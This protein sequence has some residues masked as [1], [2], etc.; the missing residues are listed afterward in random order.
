MCHLPAFAEGQQDSQETSYE[1]IA[2]DIEKFQ[3]SGIPAATLLNAAWCLALHFYTG[4]DHISFGSADE[5]GRTVIKTYTL[6][7][8]DT[9][10]DI[11]TQSA[12]SSTCGTE[13]G[14]DVTET[15]ETDQVSSFFNTV[16][17]LTSALDGSPKRNGVKALGATLSNGIQLAVEG[18]IDGT[19]ISECLLLFRSSFMSQAEAQ[20]LAATL[21]HLLHELSYSNDKPI[22]D[23]QLSKRDRDQ[24][25]QWNSVQTFQSECLLHEAITQMARERPDAGAIDAWDGRLNYKGLEITSNLLGKH[26]IRQGVAPGSFVL[27]NFEKSLWAVVSWL[28]VLKAGAACVFLDRRQ[29]INRV[30]QIIGTT[31]ATHALTDSSA[32]T[33]LLKLGM[34]VVQVPSQVPLLNGLH[35]DGGQTWPRPHPEDAAFIIFTSGSTGTPKGVILTHSGIYTTAQDM[36]QSL[37]VRRDSRILQFCSYTFDMSVAD[38]VTSLLAGACICIPSESDR[39]DHLQK[40]LQ[41]VH[42][43]WAILTPTVARLLNPNMTPDMKTLILGGELVRESDIRP[44]V[45]AGVHVYNGYGPA[46][47]TFLA[48]ITPGPIIGRASSIGRGLNMR[49]WIV[50]PVRNQLAPIGAVGELVVEGPVLAVGYLN[51]PTKTAKS[52]IS[53]PRWAQLDIHDMTTRR[54]FYKTGDLARYLSDGSLE[55]IG[56]ADTQIK[57]GGQRIELSD[58]EHHIRTIT[59]V[60]DSAVVYLKHGPL[61]GRLTAVV[62][63]SHTSAVT[64]E[65]G[66]SFHPCDD[67]FVS[68][69]KSQL[70]QAVARYMVPSVWFRVTSLPFSPTGKLD[71]PAL[72]R[73]LETFVQ[74]SPVD[75]PFQDANLKTT[76][77]N[78]TEVMLWRVCSNVL[79][80]PLNRVNLDRSFFALG[81]DSITT[82]QVVSTLR[83]AGKSLRVKDL[84]SSS[85]LRE[86]ASKIGE[87][88]TRQ[89]LP[90]IRAG[91]RFPT[92]PIQQMFFKLSMSRNTR[93]HFNQSVSVRLRERRD[94]NLI[95]KAIAG[96]VARHSM[97][98]ARFEQATSGRWMQYITEDI[99]ESYQFEYHPSTTSDLRARLMLES[100]SS[101]SAEEG[102]LIRV[103]MFEGSGVQYLFLVIHHLVV[104]LVSWRIILEELE[105]SLT[106]DKPTFGNSFPFLDWVKQQREFARTVSIDRVLPQPVPASNFTFWGIEQT[107][108]TYADVREKRFSI[109]QDVTKDILF[110]SH[111]ALQTEPIDILIAALLRSFGKTFP[112]RQ[113]PAIFTE[114]HGREPWNDQIDISRTVGWFTTVYPIYVG[115]FQDILDLVRKVK[116]ARKRTPNNGFDYFSASF[117]ES[118]P[119]NA[120]EDHFP[121]EIIFNY[122]G[123]YQLLEKK[124]SLLRQESWSA[125]EA[126]DDMSPELQRFSL[127]EIAASV[128]DDRLQFTFAWNFNLRHQSKIELWSASIPQAINQITAVLSSSSRQLTLSDLGQF[129]ITYPELDALVS[130]IRQIPAISSLEDVEDVYPCSPMQ[131]SLALSQSRVDNVYEVDILWEVTSVD[132]A[133]IDPNR[134]ETAWRSVVSRHAALRTV[135]I[136]T[137]ATVGMLDQVVLREHNPQCMHLQ[138]GNSDEAL[139]KLAHYPDKQKGLGRPEPPHRLLICSTGDGRAFLRF[140]VNHIVFD[141]MSLN[142]MLRDLSLAYVGRLVT[143]WDSPYASFIRY[144]R[145]PKLREESIS[146]WKQYLA[147]AE[148]CIFPSL[149][150]VTSGESGQKSAPVLLG[151]THKELKDKLAELEV[152]LPVVIQLVW[153]LV[154]RL[155]TNDSQTVTGYLTS[156]RDAPIAGIE[157]AIGPFISM[158]LCYVDFTQPRSLLDLLKK[159]HEDSVNSAAHQASSLAEIQKAIGIS[160]GILF[161]AGISFMPLLDERAQQGAGLLFEEKSIKDPTEFELALIVET[162]E[163][164]T[165]ISIHYRTSYISDGHATNIAATVNHIL[166]ETLRDPSQTPDEIPAISSHDLQQLWEWNKSCIEPVEECVHHFVERTMHDHPSK[167]A[168]FSWDGSLSYRELDDLSRNLAHQLKNFGLGP[169][170]IVPLC[171]EKSK[172][173][174]VSMLAVL[175][176]GACFVM[177]DP[178]HPNAR[179]IA[180]AEEVE[181]EVLLC[182]PLTQPKFEAIRER[183][184]VVESDSAKVLPPTDPT[185]PVC[186]TVT[187]DN[188]MY[189]VFTSGTTGAPKGSITSHRAYCTGFREHAWAIEVGPESRTLQFSAYSFDASVGDILTTLL[190]GGCICIPSEEDRTAEISNFI[191]QSRA[192]WAGWT[193]SF[194]SL[195]DPDTVPTLTVLLMA[196]EPLPASQVDAWVDR[197]KLLNIYGPSECSVACVVNK[198]V[199]RETNASN[200]GRGYR[201]VTWVVDE[202]DHERLRP[203]GSVGELL[204]EGPILA[205]GYL[206]MPEKTAEVFIDA[207][208]W[209]KNGSHPRTNRLYKTGDLVRYNSD[210]TINFIGRKDTQLKINGQRVEI[211][212]IEQSLRSSIPSAAGPVVVDL[213]K[214]SG[215]HDL[216]AAFINVGTEHTSPKDPDDIIAADPTALEKFQGLVKQIFDTAS[217]LPRYMSPQVFIPLKALPIT[218]AGK[219]DRRALQRVTSRLSRD[220]LVSFT[221]GAKD[222]G[223]TPEERL[224]ADLWRKVL[225]VSSV[226]IHDKFF[227]LGGDSMAAMSLRSEARH[228]GWAISVSDIFSN[229]VLADMAKLMDNAIAPDTA[230]TVEPFSLLEQ[231]ESVPSLVA[232]V[233]QECDVSSDAIEDILPCVP[234]Q[235]GLMAL[236]AR[237]PLA[238]TY[239]LHAPYRLPADIDEIRFRSA[240]EKTTEAH[241]VLRSRI[242]LKPQGALLV[243]MKDT[244][245]VST[246]IC[247]LDEYMDQQRH[248]AF[249]YGTPLLRLGLVREGNDRYFVFNAHH[250]IYDGWSSRLIWDT[251]LQLYRGEQT[252]SAP[253]FQTLVQKLQAT[254][255]GPSEDYW[256]QKMIHRQGESF[257]LVP[258]L[259]KPVARSVTSF[260]FPLPAASV[261]DRNVTSATLIN[262]VWAIINA[263]YSADSTATYGCTLSGRDF[264]LSGIEKL[265]GPTIVTVP[266]Q[267]VVRGDQS[268]TD[269]LNYVQKVSIESI[270]H[271]HLGLYEIQT[272]NSAARQAYDFASLM[273]VHPDAALRLPF[274]DINI[275][276]VPFEMTESY[277]Y[278]LVVEFLPEDEHLLVDVKFDPD[279]MDLELVNLVMHHFNH[280]L[281]GV[282]N[283]GAAAVL[284]DVMNISSEDL[285]RIE[286]WNSGRF[287]STE[288]CVHHLIEKKVREQ[289]D[290][291]AVVS[292]DASLSYAEMDLWAN[293]LSNQ[294]IATNLVDTG[295]F[296]GLCLD[297]SARAVPAMVAILKAGGAFLPLDPDHPPARL[298]ALLEEA[299]VKLVLV[300]PDRLASLSDCMSIRVMPVGD[301]QP[302]Q[303]VTAPLDIAVTPAHAAYLLFTS[304]STGKPKGVVMEHRAWSSA[305]AAQSTYFGFGPH[306]RM[307]QFSSYT[308]DA[309]IFEIFITLTS[310]GCVCAP[311]ESERM[312]N[313]SGY[314]TREKVNA[315][316]STPSVTRLLVPANVPTLKLVMVGG[317]PLA[318]SDIEGWLGQPGVS[319]VN[320][321][322]PTEA[323]VMATGRKVTL[324]DSSSN[325]GVPIGTATWVVSPSTRA[326]APIG[327]VGELCIEGPTLARGYLGDPER[328][329]I[330][331]ERNPPYLPKGKNR[332]I[333][334]TGDLVRYNSDGTLTFVGRSDGQIKL[335]GQRIEIGEIEENIRKAMS[336]NAAFKHVGVELYDSPDSNH[337]PFLAAFLVMNIPYEARVS[338]IGCASMMDPSK[339]SLFQI[340]THLQQ[341][342]RNT[343]PGYMVPSAYVSVE[344]LPTTTSSKRDRVFVKAILSQLS[345][346]GLLFP[347]TSGKGDQGELFGREKLLQGWWAK[348]LKREPESIGAGDHFFALG[349]NSIT[350]I[351]LAGMVR[352]SQYRLTY[353]DIFSFPLLS[354]MASR[355]ATSSSLERPMPKPFELMSAAELDSVVDHVLPLYGI[356][357]EEVEDIYPCTPLQEGLMAVTA[358]NFGAYISSDAMEI[359]EIELPLMREAWKAA[360]KRFELLRTRIILSHEYG[361]FQ[362]V[363]QQEPIW[364][365]AT[366]AQSFLRLVQ[367]LHGYGKPMVHHA[368]VP[369]PKAGVVQVIFSSHHSVYDGWSLGLLRQFVE[370]HLTGG[371]AESDALQTVPFKLFISHLVDQDLTEARSYWREK[372]IGLEALPFPRPPHDPKHQPLATAVLEQAVSLPKPQTHG[373]SATIATIVRAACSLTI[374]HYTASSDTIFGAI[375]TGRENTDI[376]GIE[377]IAGPTIATVPTRTNIDYDSAV[378]DFLAGVQRNSVVESRF[379]QL[380]L[381]GIARISPEC[382]QSCDFGSILVVQPPLNSGSGMII[383]QLRQGPVASPKFFPQAM[384]LD[385]QPSDNSDNMSVTLSYDPEMVG[386]AHAACVL[387]TF[388]TLLVSLI[389]ASPST[390]L[391][392]LAGLSGEHISKINRITRKKEPVLVDVC[393]H[394]LIR[395]QVKVHPNKIAIDSWDGSMTYTELDAASS[396]LAQ[397]L[398]QIG[399]G[400]QKAAPFMFEKSKWAIVSMLAIWKAGGFFV[401][402]DPKSPNRRL[403]HI[404]QATGA[405]IIL[406]STQYSDRCQELECTPVS[407]NEDT[408]PALSEVAAAIQSTVKTHD[409]A[410]VLFTSGTTGVPKGVM[411][412]HKSLSSSLTA[413]GKYM[414]LNTETRFLQS[415]AFTFDVMLLDTFAALINGGCVC[416]PSEYQKM[417]DLTGFIED[418]QINTTWFTTSLSRIIDPDS[419]PSLKTVVMGGEAVLQSDVDRWASKV[420]LIAGYGPTE[421]CIVTLVGELTPS[422]PPNTIGWPVI[423][424]A[425]VVNP[426][427]SSELAPIGGVG[428]LCIEGP[429]VARGYLGNDE[430][431]K[432][433][434]IDTP[435]WLPETFPN[436]R[437]YRT[438]DFV[439]Y[440]TDGTLSFFSRKDSQV[441]I[442]GQRVELSEIEEAIRHHVPSWLDVAVDVFNPEGRDQQILAAVF[443]AGERF[444]QASSGANASMELVGFMKKLSK[445][446]KD[447]LSETLPGH[448]IPDAYIPLPRL[449]VQTSGKLDRRALQV[450]VNSMSLKSIAAYANEESHVQKPQTE[451][452]CVLARLWYTTLKISAETSLSTSDNFFSLGGDSILAMRLVAL[453]RAEGYSLAVAQIFSCPTLSGMASKMQ[454]AETNGQPAV[455]RPSNTSISRA[456]SVLRIEIANNHNFELHRV[457]DVYPCTYMQESFVEDSIQVPGAHVVQFIFTLDEKIDLSR[458]HMAIDRCFASFPIL[459]TR[460]VR[461]ST[462]LCQVVL[463]DQISWQEFSNASLDSVLRNDKLIPTSL[464]DALT[465]VSVVYKSENLDTCLIWTLHH[466]LYDAWSLRLLLDAVDEAYR[467]DALQIDSQLPFKQLT[468]KIASRDAAVDRSF[469]ASY[470]AGAGNSP[471]FG[472]LFVRNPVK[473]MRAEYQLPLPRKVEGTTLTATI[474]SAWIRLV[475]A[476][477]RSQDVTIGYLVTGRAASIP[478][479]E[480]CMGPAISKIPLRVRFESGDSTADV[481]EKVH[482][483]LTRL[484]PYELSGLKTVK[485]ASQDAFDACRFPLDLTVHPHGTLSFAGE[486]IGMRFKGGEVAAAPPGSFAVEC[487]IKDDGI[488]ISTQWDKRAAQKEEMDDLLEKFEAVLLG[489]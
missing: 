110:N 45:D 451:S 79:N 320:A 215:E 146:Y 206:K 283:A 438:G 42:A 464:G 457:E 41:D 440:N 124:D 462:Q 46:E 425:W 350:A 232:E 355:V 415:C 154:L 445:T 302:S 274:E 298:Q 398:Q 6:D 167:E 7:R 408:V 351:R 83:L 333:Y 254:P 161:N 463:S 225:H 16:V 205:R 67:D 235:E 179:V 422:T 375:V 487:T 233:S 117:I 212:E 473:D 304:G 209:L 479:I 131:E 234:M 358:R 256:R 454:K 291:P 53:T 223:R 295:D 121:A 267:F 376:A 84:L 427:K 43:T 21:S 325:I 364:H 228:R 145:D 436:T 316:I 208:T 402:L 252:G 360:F 286:T 384:V 447:R 12:F 156:G 395:R 58:I 202:N 310:G 284:A 192:T 24:I 137:S 313:L 262:A 35:D 434:F 485:S 461:H 15:A 73:E 477:T 147:G 138:A 109:S 237:Q 379:Y 22:V 197:L 428:E 448:M 133:K 270:P 125:G 66:V 160:G 14:N 336:K 183:V 303:N 118:E 273:V 331:F 394:E 412:E 182:S 272:V 342:L 396:F 172:W 51:D 99:D 227:R 159:V 94:P 359:L 29:P 187:P 30:R 317:E 75:L 193:P 315:I 335:R 476:L 314:I 319:F 250:A 486:G 430:A 120:F 308:F 1:R 33:S 414:W 288:A 195:I 332:R 409:P 27:L 108:N 356:R 261:S 345:T 178:T 450:A 247:S 98:R 271:Q 64:N 9:L 243:I 38:M 453:L 277:T 483:E 387:S 169:E 50:D 114:A 382:H 88:S 433:A 344:Q 97:L 371:P 296:V 136:E 240:W 150:D 61:A 468:E 122:E 419:I 381:Q 211:G 365:E 357:K 201:C 437:I 391:R 222:I 111:H 86:A 343:L 72:Q 219:L 134:L 17:R 123:R 266:R 417:N 397:N 19:F 28:A 488:E 180:I 405:T 49:T 293:Q 253:Q 372:M 410:Y 104:D 11:I 80:I 152:T 328:T 57:L 385:F 443:G 444:D 322:G 392:D 264:P 290:H 246:H 349:G 279:C 420:R 91:E 207:P 340:A 231:Y 368:V 230:D 449:P 341:Q 241:A 456:N 141:G 278:P 89:Y 34:N 470:L 186:S 431:T 352:S 85:S 330:C 112:E 452:E 37:E 115:D 113:P 163:D 62:V 238:Q 285:Y 390:S 426:L 248:Q 217:S 388:S 78:P 90:T 338:G 321:Y 361:S 71:R 149:L 54:R 242:V 416:V 216:L 173:A 185:Q 399:V 96:L 103:S 377:R 204:I 119:C 191:A 400:P 199:T 36:I 411:I 65:F 55:C 153:S 81:G 259:H 309:M 370:K 373:F 132:G 265:V 181:A 93:N 446:L 76:E 155:Y 102:P 39:L 467:N 158:L 166:M 224:L 174:V 258:A 281:Q 40:Y 393:I 236:S 198:E 245:P 294:I 105:S 363:V 68:K 77:A 292:H 25:R 305:I 282:C 116:D 469:W 151:I 300:S 221:S 214:R 439:Y 210:G 306:I 459:R 318:P 44:W 226:G 189:V 367:E 239:V 139:K 466:A 244:I 407:V 311:S 126:L 127:F 347:V 429:C 465:R 480:D 263:Q 460:I 144:I 297:K 82:M 424:R 369:T 326:L 177:L 142:P 268:L 255:C 165:R 339:T 257:P 5:H 474:A 441:K 52:F 301:F 2:V 107:K 299:N 475:G 31:S 184:F 157:G 435:S 401:P 92:S 203:I 101:L 175:R 337:Q 13:N 8:Q 190:V 423:C 280:V 478:G 484:M 106:E 276:P 403:Q 269:F 18:F 196:G 458:L 23:V 188:A 95:D 324:T 346:E 143:K 10:L 353:E 74:R 418:Y 148:A 383:P 378:S 135:F 334:H 63:T 489:A 20:N 260:K 386:D 59:T 69:A 170:K 48:T 3:Q 455:P 249:G 323:C 374:S 87:I 442:R 47:A 327:A 229:P 70:L 213:L 307:L 4:Q 56:R 128:L 100:R 389:T 26:L 432:A 362:V 275:L 406:T 366:D 168:I 421:T 129:E 251:V 164:A 348:I 200:I 312:N 413:L 329:N 32:A 380:G 130:T 481:S 482:N 289:P 218:T 287:H 171:F 471:L 176:A 220:E 162:G 404:I 472:Y 60:V 194:A 140:E 354:E